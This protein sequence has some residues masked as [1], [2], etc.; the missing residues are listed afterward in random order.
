LPAAAPLRPAA[1]SYTLNKEAHTLNRRG[2]GRFERR[3]VGRCKEWD[4]GT[5]VHVPAAYQVDSGVQMGAQGW[6]ERL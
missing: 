2:G 1:V 6:E 5:G 4:G 3:R